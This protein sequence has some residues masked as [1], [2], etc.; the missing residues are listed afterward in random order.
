MGTDLGW[1][2]DG[3]F[4]GRFRAEIEEACSSC[5][6]TMKQSTQ[7]SNLGTITGMLQMI[8]D[9][10]KKEQSGT[11]I[12]FLVEQAMFLL[13]EPMTLTNNDTHH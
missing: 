5:G 12:R 13:G 8:H 2:F 3:R 1:L 6:L 11:K 10:S 4:E 7:L 9:E